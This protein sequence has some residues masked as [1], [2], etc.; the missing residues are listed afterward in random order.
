[1]WT[2]K[3]RTLKRR[4]ERERATDPEE[5]RRLDNEERTR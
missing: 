4:L 5:E 3:K 2:E 1:M